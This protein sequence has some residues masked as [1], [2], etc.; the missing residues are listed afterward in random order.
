MLYADVSDIVN[1]LSTLAY[2][3]QLVGHTISES[4]IFIELLS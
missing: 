4:P 1:T 2:V 3:L